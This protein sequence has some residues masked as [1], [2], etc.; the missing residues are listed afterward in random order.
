MR[1]LTAL[2]VIPLLGLAGNPATADAVLTPHTAEYKVKISLLGGR[3]TTRLARSDD[4]YVATH[5]I[6]PTG[7]A[8]AIAGGEILAESEFR[9]DGDGILPLHY[10]GDDE[11]SSDKLRVDI[12]FDWNEQR[13]IGHYQTKDDPEPVA[14]DDAI[15]ASIHDPVSIQYE[16]M[17]DLAN[18]GS[19]SQYVLYEHDRIRSLTVTRIGTQT[20]E[21]KAGTFEAVGIRHQAGSSSRSTTLWFAEKLDWLPVMIERHR[22]GK[23][24]MRA[25]L[26]RYQPENE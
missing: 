15:D 16:L 24:Q 3:L 13:A 19:D 21:T 4:V 23:L 8:G 17:V 9:A 2:L 14:V 26:I 18:G 10:R 12:E 1:T 6:E 7:L 11:V 20:V 22:K 5:L 25:T